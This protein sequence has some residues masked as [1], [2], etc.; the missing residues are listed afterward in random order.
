MSALVLFGCARQEDP[1][2]TSKTLLDHIQARGFLRV[3]TRY[4]P[5]TLYEGPDRRMGFEYELAVAFA[6]SLGVV[7]RFVFRDGQEDIL[8]ALRDGEG[9]IAAAGLIRTP[10]MEKE[11]LL[12]PDY[13]EVDQQVVCRRG[14]QRPTDL[15][16]LAKVKLSVPRGS[17]HEARLRELQ[18]GVPDLSWI[19]DPERSSERIF[20]QVVKG[21][22]DCTIADSN[23]VDINRRYHP[24]LVVKFPVHET[25]SLAWVLPSQAVELQQAVSAW[26]RAMGRTGR[27]GELEDRYFGS[28]SRQYDYVDNRAFIR[29][30]DERLPDFIAR[31]KDAGRR[32][33]IPW[34]LLAAQA[35]QE[36]HWDPQAIS[37]TGVRG[38]MMLTQETAA[39]LGVKNRRNPYESIRAGAWYL[40]EMR[41]RLPPEIKDPDRTWIALAAYNVGLGHLM[42]V[43]EIVKS[44]GKDPNSW[45]SVREVL[46]LLANKDYY[47]NTKH[48][49]A[50][51]MEPVHYVR[52]IRYYYDVLVQREAM[53]NR[54]STL[55]AQTHQPDD[56]ATRMAQLDVPDLKNP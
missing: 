37:P 50:Q 28:L 53:L 25:Q 52:K 10:D 41:R 49:Y 55:L 14:G 19:S 30:I 3:V 11:F 51:G 43:R 29:R 32:Y 48:G 40:A 15:P 16:K 4:A 39:T 31:F 23:V 1:V 7:P 36:S 20:E 21:D 35:Y 18:E 56:G 26:F 33:G 22:V 24:E 54:R 6:R 5:T 12:G 47:S 38:I 9:D 13:Q 45:K 44:M 42:D 8:A 34:P 27:L 17:I 2:V 46:P